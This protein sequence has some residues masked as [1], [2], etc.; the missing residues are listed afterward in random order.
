MA[1]AVVLWMKLGEVHR[2]A[3]PIVLG[4]LI[5]SDFPDLTRRNNMLWNAVRS[6]SLYA[7]SGWSDVAYL[8]RAPRTRELYSPLAFIK[9]SVPRGSR[10]ACWQE[11]RVYYAMSRMAPSLMHDRSLIEDVLE[12]SS[13]VDEVERRFKQRGI[14]HIL[15][16]ISPSAEMKKQYMM[17]VT[18][19]EMTLFGEFLN[20]RVKLQFGASDERYRVGELKSK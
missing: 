2:V 3:L 16:C 6:F 7:R 19:R 12:Q 10:V 8:Q 14:T 9:H 4:F 18:S 11:P 1:L 13:T 20:T 5:A 15:Y 17:F